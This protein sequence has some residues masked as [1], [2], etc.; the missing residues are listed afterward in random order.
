VVSPRL[1]VGAE[2]GAR[3]RFDE[4]TAA[5]GDDA[6]SPRATVHFAGPTLLLQGKKAWISAGAYARLD[7]LADG[8]ATGDPFGKLWIR[9]IVGIDL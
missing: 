4:Q 5:A 7:R 9:T 8:A 1:S 3:G 2:S 6:D